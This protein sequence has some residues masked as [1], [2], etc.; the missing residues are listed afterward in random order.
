MQGKSK[1]KTFIDRGWAM[2]IIRKMLKVNECWNEIV[3]LLKVNFAFLQRSFRLRAQRIWS[4]PMCFLSLLSAVPKFTFSVP[5]VYFQHIANSQHRSTPILRG[6][7][8]AFFSHKISCKYKKLDFL[9]K[10]LK[11]Q[12]VKS[13][14]RFY[15]YI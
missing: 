10:V 6:V 9:I 15:I 3:A 12:K 2:L 7:V 14:Y 4:V 11:V 13:Q 5:N 1:T 8:F